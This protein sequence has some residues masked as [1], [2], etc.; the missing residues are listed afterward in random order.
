[1]YGRWPAEQI[2]HVNG[3]KGDNR[4]ANLREATPTQN[5][6]NTLARRNNKCGKKGVVLARGKWQAQIYPNGRQIKLGSFNSAEEAHAAY[7]SAARIYFG[8]F[9]RA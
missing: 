6:A 9:A 4:I 8:E 7:C 3:V 1:V 2:D 5:V